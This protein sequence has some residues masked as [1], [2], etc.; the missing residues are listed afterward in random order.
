MSQG[1]DTQPGERR[2]EDCERRWYSAALLT[3]EA[4]TCPDCGGALAPTAERPPE[5]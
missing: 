2:C 4:A 5:A 3:D 1:D